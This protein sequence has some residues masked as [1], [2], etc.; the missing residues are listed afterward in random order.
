MLQSSLRPGR[1][2]NSL[3]CNLLEFHR[4]INKKSENLLFP[5]VAE[6]KDDPKIYLNVLEFFTLAFS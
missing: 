5:H 6:E 4:E 1:R 2:L 3:A